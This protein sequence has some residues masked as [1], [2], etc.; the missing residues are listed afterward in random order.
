MGLSIEGEF[1]RLPRAQTG[2]SQGT[3]GG[4]GGPLAQ[5]H[6]G[7][8]FPSSSRS[9]DVRRQGPRQSLSEFSA[10]VR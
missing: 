3:W 6:L 7:V 10:L 1:C 4:G 8:D 9:E 5:V 2:E